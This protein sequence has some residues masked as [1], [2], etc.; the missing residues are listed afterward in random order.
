VVDE[1]QRAIYFSR[2]PIPYN[3]EGKTI[4]YWK[5]IGVYA[6]RRD[7]LLSFTK[8]PKGSLEQ[9]ESLEQLRLVEKGVSIQM[10]ETTHQAIA[11][12][13]EEDLI[14]ARTVLSTML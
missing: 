7:L 11:I 3:R 8:W 6:Y 2:S 14:Y 13:T 10:V 9:L 1:Q 12:D 5:H 4:T